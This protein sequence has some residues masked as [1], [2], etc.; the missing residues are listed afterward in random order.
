MKYFNL[1][2]DT[3][4]MRFYLLMVVV[5]VSIFAG[6]PELSFLA[7]PIFL[8]GILGITIEKKNKQKVQIINNDFT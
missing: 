2:I 3:L 1:S 6:V 5:I 4:I 8:S 7:V